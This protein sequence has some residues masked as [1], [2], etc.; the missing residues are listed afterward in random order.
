MF[1]LPAIEAWQR[2]QDAEQDA[3]AKIAAKAHNRRVV[4]IEKF[5]ARQIVDRKWICFSEIAD[6]W[7]AGRQM[8]RDE[9]YQRLRDSLLAGYFERR[10]R[11]AKAGVLFLNPMVPPEL[12]SKKKARD[13]VDCNALI[14]P[15]RPQRSP[16]ADTIRAV[17]CHCWT[18]RPCA[19]A[20]C[21]EW[22]APSEWLKI[23]TRHWPVRPAERSQPGPKPGAIDRFRD[24]DQALYDDLES[25][26][27]ERHCSP[28]EAA[29]EIVDRE[30]EARGLLGRKDE[31]GPR[32]L[33][34]AIRLKG[35]GGLDA[36]IRRLVGRH[37]KDSHPSNP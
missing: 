17:L 16:L 35:N 15:P 32:E 30:L 10:G 18:P 29:R 36:R 3:A 6:H 9:V 28:T 37:K 24:C 7:A 4:R 20:W 21:I 23:P 19:L 27:A 5:R 1:D 13:L 22:G 11:H 8:S 12:L 33:N 26:M 14:E 34:K 25:V 2:E 31:L